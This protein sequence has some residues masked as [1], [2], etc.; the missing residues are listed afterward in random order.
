MSYSASYSGKASELP[1]PLI[2]SEERIKRHDNH[3]AAVNSAVKDLVASVARGDQIVNVSAYGHVN[4]EFGADSF[5]ISIAT[6]SPASPSPEEAA[7]AQ[8]PPSNTVD[9]APEEAVP[10]NAA[11]AG[12]DNPESPDYD[13]EFAS[14]R[15]GESPEATK[16]RL[17]SE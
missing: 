4:E 1:D 10:P 6:P 12:A 3:V 17:E 8:P 15:E 9:A 2:G 14:N 7:A 13:P 11:A 5:N 16:E